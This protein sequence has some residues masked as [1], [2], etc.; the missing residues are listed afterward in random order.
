MS[1][2]P[3]DDV[4][5]H[6]EDCGCKVVV[7]NVT[8]QQMEPNLCPDHQAVAEERGVALLGSQLE[9]LLAQHP[10]VPPPYQG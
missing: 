8:V 10:R 6:N 9:R 7:R 3:P 1:T 4:V 2:T 5:V